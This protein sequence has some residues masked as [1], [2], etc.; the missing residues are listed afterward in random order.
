VCGG[1]G[2]PS[3]FV[4]AGACLPH[5]QGQ[6]HPARD[7]HLSRLFCSHQQCSPWNCKVTVVFPSQQYPLPCA[8]VAAFT[9]ACLSPC[10]PSLPVHDGLPPAVQVCHALGKVEGD[11]DL[12]SL[13]GGVEGLEEGVSQ[14]AG[15]QLSDHDVRL[16]LR[17]RTQEL[18]RHNSTDS[19]GGGGGGGVCLGGGIS[20]MWAWCGVRPV[21]CSYI[22]HV[23]ACFD[24]HCH[25][26]GGGGL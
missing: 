21:C 1:S 9:P 4:Y 6:K 16:L 25:T 23:A 22:A 7:C 19:N 12:A 2:D 10:L 18:H 20:R 26:P 24:G 5:G 14:G 13:C 3:S 15:H 17:T 8:C 11:L